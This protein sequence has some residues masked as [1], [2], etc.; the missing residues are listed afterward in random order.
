[1]HP[2]FF[3]M[4]HDAGDQNRAVLIRQRV[5]VD[6]GG[7]FQESIDQNRSRL[8]KHDRFLHIAADRIFVVGDHHRAPAQHVA[9]AH[10]HRESDGPRDCTGL[11]YVG[12]RSILR[13]RNFQIV[14]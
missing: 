14:E 10:Q 5:D 1:V 9:G 6:F 7:V 11:F 12:R 13:R 2:G 4:F 8:R 3:D